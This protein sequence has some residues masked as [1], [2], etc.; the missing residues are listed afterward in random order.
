MDLD[1]PVFTI[2]YGTDDATI[3]VDGKTMDAGADPT[4]IAAVADATADGVRSIVIRA[5]DFLGDAGTWVDLVAMPAQTDGPAAQA[6]LQ[7]LCD[8][9]VPRWQGCPVARV[10]ADGARLLRWN[11]QQLDDWAAGLPAA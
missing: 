9:Q 2:A 1:V 10:D 7:A 6:W 5:G 3:V 4:A 8:G 11:G